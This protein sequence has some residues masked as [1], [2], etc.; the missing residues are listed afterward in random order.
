MKDYAIIQWRNN[1]KITRSLLALIT[2]FFISS[3]S[4]NGDN[5]DELPIPSS[6]AI[7]A[8]DYHMENVFTNLVKDINY[9]LSVKSSDSAMKYADIDFAYDAINFELTPM[10]PYK[11]AD[12]YKEYYFILTAK[13]DVGSASLSV[14]YREVSAIE[15][16]F[17]TDTLIE[18]SLLA[19][20]NGLPSQNT[21]HVFYFADYETYASF[22]NENSIGK[23][24]TY[25]ESY[26]QNHDLALA[27]ISYSSSTL[28]ISYHGA[29][30]QEN[31][32]NIAFDFEEDEEALFDIKS[33]AYYVQLEK[34][35]SVTSVSLFKSAQFFD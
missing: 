10:Y 17:F 23:Q 21:N 30:M 4:S 34:V 27:N 7:T 13:Q 15:T 14:S 20:T 26:F 24:S 31:T 5:I 1:M 28:N 19:F 11:S 12:T 25:N 6:I 35:T 29:F 2:L 3:C 33:K 18:S 9:R 16:Y 32:L 22:D 8:N